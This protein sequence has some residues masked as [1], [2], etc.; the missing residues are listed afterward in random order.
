M[1]ERLNQVKY[2]AEV[3]R[4]IS[5]EELDQLAT[6]AGNENPWFTADSVKESIQGIN[7]MLENDK[8]DKWV[9][10]YDFTGDQKN[11][12]LVFAGN[13]P[14]VGFHDL[15]SVFIGGHNALVKLSHQDQ[16]LMKFVIKLLT[17]NEPEAITIQEQLKGHDAIIATGSTNTSRYFE[18]YF[19]KY[20]NIIRSNRTS[21]A[22]LTGSESDDELK[23]LGNDIFSYFGLGCRNVSHIFIPESFKIERLAENWGHHSDIINHHKYANNYDYQKSI[24]LVNQVEH[25]DFG[26]VLLKRASEIH[27]PISVLNYSTYKNDEEVS[28]V[29]LEH[30]SN[31]QCTVGRDVAFGR[32]QMPDLTD[33]ADGVDTM[34]FL[35]EL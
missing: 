10:A 25:L 3:L 15:L 19:G 1:K 5:K 27:T 29:L 22:V 9:S 12:G 11:V 24:L 16:V 35:A 23:E 7:F 21:V 14:M 8:L 30:E 20:P 31:I 32:S 34:K 6:S 18:H 33:Y 2:L 26:F 17:E 4:S 13:I 28:S